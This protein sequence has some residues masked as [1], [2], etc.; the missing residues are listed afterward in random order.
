MTRIIRVEVHQF[1]YP[2]R[3]LGR[4][5]AANFVY[6]PDGNALMD[7][8]AV[9]LRADDGVM[10]EYVPI[11]GGK[12]AYLGQVLTV[13]PILLGMDPDQRELFY[14]DA[15]RVLRHS[16]AI[17]GSALDCALWDMTGK[18]LGTSVAR[19]L[20]DTGSACQLMRARCMQTATVAL[21]P[22][23]RLASSHCV[24]ASW[25]LKLSRS[26]VGATVTRAKRRQTYC[27]CA[28]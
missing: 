8:F 13:A 20:E 21:T 23:K 11:F 15:K 28:R 18:R 24:V 27:T 16:G 10:G 26:M 6:A 1:S 17:G 4:D 22:K 25:A 2:V 7:S 14:T 19:L 5:H 3:H 9:R 12:K